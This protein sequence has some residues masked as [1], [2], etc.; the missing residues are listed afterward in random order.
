MKQMNNFNEQIKEGVVL[1]DFF[2]TW[3]GPCKM[4]APV[5]EELK[6]DRSDV[7]VVKIDVDQETEIAR[8][9]GVMSIPTLILFKDGKEVAKNVGFMPKELLVQWINE[10]TK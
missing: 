7:K 10:Q 9:Y 4:Q 8:L 3:C 5:L 6:E 2:A 1:V